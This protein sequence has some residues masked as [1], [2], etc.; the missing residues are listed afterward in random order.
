MQPA[1]ASAA[2]FDAGRAADYARQSRIALAG[3]EACH[4]L[5]A[6]L[7]SAALD[8]E[9][10]RP[11][12]CHVLV[13]GAGG[14][15]Q[16][17]QS[18]APLQPTW[19]FTAVDPSAQMLEQA[20]ARLRDLRLDSRTRVVRG[21]VQD[22]GPATFDAATLIG[23]VHHLPGDAAKREILQAIATR[24]P[25]GAPFILAGNTHAYA[26]R[27]L[28]L[29]AWAQRWRMAGAEPD[30]VRARLATI[31]QG[32]DP[33]VDEAASLALLHDTG[34]VRAERFFSS[35]FWTGWIAFRA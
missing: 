16:E 17:I 28:L 10:A 13:V 14:T 25:P 24:L 2:K 32:A 18:I 30:E 15:A 11:T 1:A 34:F 27:P 6:C 9:Q 31:L 26:S 4:A 3:Y 23:V 12:P 21:S 22:L 19:R 7:L 33:P 29:Q 8:P 35:L 5:A 20:V